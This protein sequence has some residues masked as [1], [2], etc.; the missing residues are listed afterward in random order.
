MLKQSEDRVR[1]LQDLENNKKYRSIKKTTSVSKALVTGIALTTMAPND[2]YGCDQMLYLKSNGRICY[3]DKCYDLST[4]SLSLADGE[5]ACFNDLNNEKLSIKLDSIYNI[6]RFSSLYDTS[7]YDI[8]NE[9]HWNCLG[10]G[11]CWWGEECGNGYKLNI[12][13]RNTKEPHGYGCHMTS[14][15]CVGSMCTHGTSCV[16]YRW[17]I[18]PKGPKI[19]VY[20]L[21]SEI[22]EVSITIRYKDVVRHIVLNTNNPKYDMNNILSEIMDHMPFYISGVSYEKQHLRESLISINGT[23]FNVDSSPHNMPQ[24]GMIGDIQIDKHN[25]KILYYDNNL[26][27]S[28]D[29]CKVKCITNEPAIN[30]LTDSSPYKVDS[31]NIQHLQM[32]NKGWINYKYRSSGHG[33]ISFGNVELKELIVEKPHCEISV[34]ISYACEACLEQPRATLVSKNLKNEGMMEFES[35]C[36]WD[37]SSVSCNNEMYDIVQVSKNKYCNIY[38]PLI[39]QSIDITFEYEYRGLLTDMKTIRA[40]TST[41]IINELM[42]NQSFITTLLTSLSGFMLFTGIATVGIK[43]LRLGVLAIGKKE[44]QNA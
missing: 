42:G 34:G 32:Y 27:C 16:W 3:S 7:S 31:S 5:T 8:I 23:Y 25:D 28:V 33:T 37:R 20:S 13:E 41:D 19:P 29:S 6:A 14:V 36:T 22:W 26:D 9:M 43:V 40:E 44:V 12:L 30:R 2:T 18:N 39:N 10:S 35:N 21:V 1:F 38:I 17:Q 11:K 24:R 15:S 4:Y